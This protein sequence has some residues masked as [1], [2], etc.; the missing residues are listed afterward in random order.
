MAR[1]P[2]G[3]DAFAL[4]YLRRVDAAL[5]EIARSQATGRARAYRE[6]VR[7]LEAT[8]V[9]GNVAEHMR[10]AES[11]LARAS[12]DVSGVALGPTMSTTDLP[13]VPFRGAIRDLATRVPTFVEIEGGLPAFER[14]AQVY[15]DG[16]RFTLSAASVEVGAS[17]AARSAAQEI[18]ERSQ[19]VVMRGQ[20]EGRS[21]RAI[22]KALA[23]EVGPIS[24][25][26]AENIV[27]TNLSTAQS[28]GM[29]QQAARPEVRAVAPALRY[30]AVGDRDT[31]A[32]HRAASGMVLTADD[33]LMEVW[34]TPNGYNSFVPETRV[35]GDVVSAS[36]A[37]YSGPVVRI[38][39]RMGRRLTVTPN[40]PVLVAGRGMA[41]AQSVREG[42][43]AVAHL[44]TLERF[45]PRPGDDGTPAPL[46]FG[47]AIDKQQVPP[48][49]EDVFHAA[50]AASVGGPAIES[51]SG[52][53][54]LDFHGDA[55]FYKGDVHV[56]SVDG[57]LPADVRSV[58]REEIDKFGFVHSGSAGLAAHAA[59]TVALRSDSTLRLGVVP[60]IDTTLLEPVAD[61]VARGAYLLRQLEE[62]YPHEIALDEVI[63][64]KILPH[65]G[66]VY[67][68][69]S[70]NGFI[71]AEGL[72][73]SNCRCRWAL[74]SVPWLKRMDLWDHERGV[75]IRYVPP[76][77]RSGRATPDEGFA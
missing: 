27:R 62:R 6:A 47:G 18:A 12:V 7:K 36:K 17:D 68:L 23:E 5:L 4:E 51:L 67:D 48:S 8:I 37:A 72:F 49:I 53:L 54:P 9:Y 20:V 10:A 65:R 63:R 21:T 3:P 60:Q 41:P 46:P 26:Y 50:R 39:T 15:R 52:P 70:P 56:V 30:I 75:P 61:G 13:R 59:R 77:V 71:V 11:V 14:V 16:G 43:Y 29:L 45:V 1:D 38:E 19:A 57:L 32:N 35:Q 74:A 69:Q 66:H 33:P 73:A 22:S 31:R 24:E 25:A 34:K 76:A 42:E 2:T 64:V 28:N 55:R 58:F 40:H 44:P